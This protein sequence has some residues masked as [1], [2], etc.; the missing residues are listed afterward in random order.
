MTIEKKL[1]IL[2]R[3][4]KGVLKEIE[5]QTQR[6]ADDLKDQMSRFFEEAEKERVK[7]PSIFIKEFYKLQQSKQEE[8]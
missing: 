6:N 1:Q 7:G 3:E 2:E 4:I 5:E 8:I